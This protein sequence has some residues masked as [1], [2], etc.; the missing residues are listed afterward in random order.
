MLGIVLRLLGSIGVFLFGMRIM[1]DGIQ[2][3]AGEKLQTAL[4]YMTNNSVIA[5]FSGFLLSSFW[6]ILLLI[7]IVELFWNF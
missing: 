6:Q 1:S 3:V 7:K 4:N 2:K 5:V